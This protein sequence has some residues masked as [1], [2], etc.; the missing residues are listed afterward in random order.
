MLPGGS[1]SD[2]ASAS[3]TRDDRRNPRLHRRLHGLEF[4]RHSTNAE[5][6]FFLAHK[7]RHITDVVHSR[8]GA[9]LR[10]VQSVH[11]RQQ[12]EQI[13]L[14]QNRDLR[15][16]PIIVAEIQL[17]DRHRVVLVDDRHDAT[18]EQTRERVAHI[19]VG[20]AAVEVG[21]GEEDLRDGQPVFLK[22]LG[23]SGH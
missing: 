16:E 13:G 1:A 15:A 23:V 21:V 4:R 10:I 3:S 9:S 11:A 20:A 12:H 19:C 22:V 8:D 14:G 5:P 7:F 18:R 2:F 6:P 17:L